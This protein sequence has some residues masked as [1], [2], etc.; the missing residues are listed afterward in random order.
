MTAFNTIVAVAFFEHGAWPHRL[1]SFSMK[2]FPNRRSLFL[3]SEEVLNF[4]FMVLWAN[5]AL[6]RP[7]QNKSGCI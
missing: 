5:A 4:E 6:L 2:V 1:M 7:T 3:R